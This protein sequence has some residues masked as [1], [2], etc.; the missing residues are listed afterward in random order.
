MRSYTIEPINIFGCLLLELYNFF[1][2]LLDGFHFFCCC[3][4]CFSHSKFIRKLRSRSMPDC[5]SVSRHYTEMGEEKQIEF[6]EVI[7]SV[8]A[9]RPS[10]FISGTISIF[11]ESESW[12]V[13]KKQL[14]MATDLFSKWITMFFSPLC[15]FDL[16][17]DGL[18]NAL[19][20]MHTHSP[21]VSC[22]IKTMKTEKHSLW[23]NGKT[24][25]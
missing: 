25:F 3:C 19:G 2:I 4:C 8:A 24:H 15:L 23:R 22:M 10:N 11:F 13:I 5:V 14:V 7:L 16:F 9:K 6:F 20:P 17:L 12:D 18:I 21:A 1:S